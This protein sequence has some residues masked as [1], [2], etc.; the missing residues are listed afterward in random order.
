MV[1]WS[2]DGSMWL[3]DATARRLLGHPSL[4]A[5]LLFVA[6][7]ATCSVLLLFLRELRR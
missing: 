4:A 1:G 3:L 6:L 5:L 2:P 7:S